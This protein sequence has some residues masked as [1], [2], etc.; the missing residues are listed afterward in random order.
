M[1]TQLA[2]KDRVRDLIIKGFK[3]VLIVIETIQVQNFNFPRMMIHF[4]AA[5][6]LH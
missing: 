3:I 6:A 5:T 2:T 4:A 1:D